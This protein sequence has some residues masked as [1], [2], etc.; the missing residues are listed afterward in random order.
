LVAPQVSP[1][2]V[3]A[4]RA[5][6]R[7]SRPPRTTRSISA[8]EVCAPSRPSTT[9]QL[10]P[11]GS[12]AATWLWPPPHA[13]STHAAAPAPAPTAVQLLRYTRITVSYVEPSVSK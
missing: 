1:V 4:P 6:G 2:F 3:C 8:P 7:P 10:S 9:T 11:A 12:D 13:S 5:S